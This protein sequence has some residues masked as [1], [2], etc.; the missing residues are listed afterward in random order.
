MTW[1][2]GLTGHR[3]YPSVITVIK[4]ADSIQASVVW[5]RLLPLYSKTTGASVFNDT[6]YRRLQM[7]LPISNTNVELK[8]PFQDYT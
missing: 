6:H 8:N 4:K 2:P 1:P 5:S 3:P 7:S